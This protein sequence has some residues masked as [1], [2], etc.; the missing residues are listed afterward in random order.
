MGQNSTILPKEKP[1]NS[2]GRPVVPFGKVLADIA[3]ILRTSCNWK[4]LS[5]EYGFSSTYYRQFQK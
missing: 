1:N 5:K 3:Y 4:L 2:I